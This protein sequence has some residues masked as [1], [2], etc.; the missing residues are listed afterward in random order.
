MLTTGAFQTVDVVF[1]QV[2]ESA[3][4]SITIHP[5]GAYLAMAETQSISIWR[6]RKKSL[7]GSLCRFFLSSQADKL[8]DPKAGALP[9]VFVKEFSGPRG[10]TV[11]GSPPSIAWMDGKSYTLASSYGFQGIR[12]A[13]C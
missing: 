4:S 10:H 7:T 12:Y 1:S 13:P 9:W 2:S 5:T 3:V 11:S 6:Q 8:D